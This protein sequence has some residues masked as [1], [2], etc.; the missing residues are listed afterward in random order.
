MSERRVLKVPLAPATGEPTVYA[1]FGDWVFVPMI[2]APVV[3]WIR[4]RRRTSGEVRA[5]TEGGS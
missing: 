5:A 3:T 2:L 4:S 1:R